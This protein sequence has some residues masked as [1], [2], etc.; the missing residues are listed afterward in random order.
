MNSITEHP[1]AEVS[2]DGASN[3]LQHPSWQLT[4]S[5]ESKIG[6]FESEWCS[7][8]HKTSLNRLTIIRGIS[9]VED[10]VGVFREPSGCNVR[11][12][13]IKEGDTSLKTHTIYRIWN[14][15]NRGVYRILE[16]LV[17]EQ[18]KERIYSKAKWKSNRKKDEEIPGQQRLSYP[19]LVSKVRASNQELEAVTVMK[20]RIIK[21]NQLIGSPHL[22][23]IRLQNLRRNWAGEYKEH[24]FWRQVAYC[25]TEKWQTKLHIES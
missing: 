15:G 3:S 10:L 7:I 18:K 14:S 16:I 22:G 8:N 4:C 13:S 21:K 20:T 9:S 24:A 6:K 17:L 2:P 12:Y 1:F 5:R 19:L 23:W 11:D 25:H